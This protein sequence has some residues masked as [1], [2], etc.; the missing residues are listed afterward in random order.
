MCSSDL[1][2][3]LDSQQK[4][5][6]FRAPI[7][8]KAQNILDIGTGQGNWAVD[9]AQEFPSLTV[10]GVD[11]YPPPQKWVPP[12]CIFEVDD[13]TKEWNWKERFDLIHIRQLLAALTPTQIDELY[14]QAYDNMVPGGWIEQVEFSV[15][16]KSM[17][18]AM[19]KDSITA[20]L[21]EMF[22]E[23]CDNAGVPIDIEKTMRGS[24]E[25]AGFENVKEIEYKAPIGSWPKHKVYKDA[26]IMNMMSWKNGTE[27]MSLPTSCDLLSGAATSALTT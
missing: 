27:G 2:T 5:P 19:P 15:D 25:K 9:V 13:I 21:Y 6:F 10:R 14:K 1:N 16:I 23:V 20:G 3:I 11:L 18:N 8:S 24:I 4:N 12:N 7:S 22:K 26:G 17:N